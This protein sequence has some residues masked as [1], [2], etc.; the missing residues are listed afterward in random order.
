[1]AGVGIVGGKDRLWRSSPPRGN[2]RHAKG[3]SGSEPH[4]T[5][6]EPIVEA[7]WAWM[8]RRSG[9]PWIGRGP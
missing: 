9:S 1:M 8:L 5:S 3:H 4:F 2:S 6:L 7:A